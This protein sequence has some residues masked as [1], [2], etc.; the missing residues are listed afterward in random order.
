[1][2]IGC[3]IIYKFFQTLRV[4]KIDTEFNGRG[5]AS[6]TLEGIKQFAEIRKCTE[7]GLNETRI[8]RE[9]VTA[10]L[11]VKIYI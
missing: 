2:V 4:F 1:M 3:Y 7:P 9:L 11:L 8:I 5:T 6:F 10:V